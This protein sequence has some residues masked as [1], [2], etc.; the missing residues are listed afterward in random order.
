MM[1]WSQIPD[2]G[3][4]LLLGCAYADVAYR[5]NE[6]GSRI[7]VAGWFLIAVHFA[8]LLLTHSS[9]FWEIAAHVIGLAALA[10]AGLLLMWASVS[11]RRST[12]VEWTFLVLL[13]ANTFYIGLSAVNLF[14]DWLLNL[15]A[16]LFGSMPLAVAVVTRT[17]VSNLRWTIIGIYFALSVFLLLFQHQPGNGRPLALGGV[18]CVLFISCCLLFWNTYG[19]ATAGPFIVAAGFLTW[20][21]GSLF[22]PVMQSILPGTRVASEVWNL[23]IYVVGAGMILVLLENQIDQNR[24]MSEQLA[25]AALHDPL[26]GLANRRL[27]ENRGR[28]S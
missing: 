22:E 11:D 25:H 21:L 5:S 4:V 23:P 8:A 20:A 16:C 6:R 17:R 2:L 9:P 18:Y 7:W 28:C 24:Q 13:F 14:P 26:T 12:Y 1:D 15:S 3:A 10:W 27:F 19:R